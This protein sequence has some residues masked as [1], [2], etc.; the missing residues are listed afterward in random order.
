[1]RHNESVMKISSKITTGV[2][3]LLC[4]IM[5]LCGLLAFTSSNAYSSILKLLTSHPTLSSWLPLIVF[6]IIF[7]F[8]FLS[9]TLRSKGGGRLTWIVILF[10]LPSILSFNSIDILKVIGLNLTIASKLTFFQLLG[11]CVLIITCYLLISFMSVLKH[12]RRSLEKRG[13]SFADINH[14]NSQSHPVLMLAVASA[15]VA[16]AIIALIA[17]GLESLTFDYLSYV[18]W[19]VISIG[20]G[21]IL[22]LAIYLYWLG[23]RRNSSP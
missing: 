21:C 11:L 7:I 15:L 16:A 10:S 4:G 17:W 12:S 3:I 23:S 2:E 18:P 8:G 20:L 13:S 22:I 14:V 6:G 5:S 19:T 9:V 1:M